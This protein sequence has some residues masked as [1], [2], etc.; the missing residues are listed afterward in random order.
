MST[1]VLEEVVKTWNFVRFRAR[2]FE[3]NNYLWILGYNVVDELN[4]KIVYHETD[5][6]TLFG[7]K[8]IIDRV[9]PNRIDL[10]ANVSQVL[11]DQHYL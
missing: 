3:F 11:R 5:N 8:V 9:D 6:S 7:I 4:D 2:H 10:F 1:S